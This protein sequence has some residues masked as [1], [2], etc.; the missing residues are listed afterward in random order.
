M[1]GLARVWNRLC[2]RPSTQHWKLEVWTLCTTYEDAQITITVVVL[3][4][5]SG[6]RSTLRASNLQS[7]PGGAYPHT[8]LACTCLYPRIQ[9]VRPPKSLPP[10]FVYCRASG[11]MSDAEVAVRPNCL[12]AQT[13]KLLI[14]FTSTWPDHSYFASYAFE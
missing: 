6:L 5:K 13:A 2:S 1:P 3:W 14:Y 9:T 11:E 4:A 8:S 12:S 7:F 10:A